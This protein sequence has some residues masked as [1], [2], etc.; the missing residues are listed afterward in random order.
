MRKYT[1]KIAALYTIQALIFIVAVALTL[2][3][4]RYLSSFRILMSVIIIICWVASAIFGLWLLPMY[5]RRTVVY[6][7]TSE[8]SVHS[9]LI[10]LWREHMKASA[11][12][13]V[14]LV[15][16][17]LSSLTGFNFVFIHALGGTVVLPFL[18]SADA[19]EIITLLNSRI[20][21]G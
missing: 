18:S 21:E 8:I 6:I 15:R 9:G 7:G 4:V 14:S 12:Q 5:F 2:L 3:S 13:Y 20:S 17:P 16:A 19:E 1:P 11:V 10:F